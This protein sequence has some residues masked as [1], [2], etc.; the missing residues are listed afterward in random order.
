MI[1]YVGRLSEEKGVRLLLSAA[2]SLLRE[3]TDVQLV[4]AGDGPLRKTLAS[5]GL[6]CGRVRLLGY[7][8]RDRIAAFMA[9]A[10]VV[11]VP[12]FREACATVLAEAMASG[13]AIVASNAGGTPELLDGNN[14]L[15]F[16]SGAQR[17]IA[18]AL[19]RVVADPALRAQ[20]GENARAA[21][22]RYEWPL[23]LL[24]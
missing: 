11:V 2:S 16:E 10:D 9:A 8:P 1:L 15:L 14:G 23:V 12:S 19:E 3:R 21:S 4:V 20:L 5:E 24:R 6:A 22:H 7:Q 17:S 18:S 13:K